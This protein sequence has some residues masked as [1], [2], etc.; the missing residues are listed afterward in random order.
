MPK[1]RLDQALVNKKLVASR[2]QA[3]S[4]IK[5]G[6]VQVDGKIID[7]AG[8]LVDPDSKITLSLAEQFVSRA[9]LKL[10]SVAEALE[11]DF[12]GKV[13]LDVGSSTGGFTD[14]ALKKG[15]AKIIAV[16]VGSNQLHA[17]LRNRPA[18]ELH[19]NTDIRDV[20]S[21]SHIPDIVLV[22]VSFISLREV[23]PHISQL[24][25]QTSQIVAMLKPQFE[26]GVRDLHKGVIKNH[27]LRRQRLKSF[28]DWAKQ[29]FKIV[30]KADSQVAGAK[31]NI[32]RFYLLT[33]L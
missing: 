15:A 7:K 8:S 31:G 4:Y 32:E 12:R 1:I 28:E 19:E 10:A 2:S 30:G 23:L 17:S 16:D 11:L 20:R 25:G 27:K 13:I 22:D 26:A 14:Y 9:A 18:V 33:P 24:S 29:Y 3:E 6:Y 21:L 5:L